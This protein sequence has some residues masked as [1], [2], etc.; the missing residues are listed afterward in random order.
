[1]AN[2][3]KYSLYSV[4]GDDE[5]IYFEGKP[6]KVAYVFNACKDDIPKFIFDVLF[7][8]III[9]LFFMLSADNFE[10]GAKAIIIVLWF[11]YLLPTLNMLKIPI[12]KMKE[13]KNTYYIITDK[14]IYIQFG[15]NQIYYRTYP[16]ERIG[17]KVFYRKNKADD[18]FGV[19]TLGFS[20][21]DY[22]EERIMS[23]KD[24]ESLYSVL[25]DITNSR[26]EEMIR[27]YEERQA[28]KRE[29]EEQA[30]LLAQE[31]LFLQQQ[32]EEEEKRR[33]E[34]YERE[35]QQHFEKE[36]ESHERYMKE[37]EERLRME[38]ELRNHYN[39][40]DDDDDDDEDE[41]SFDRFRRREQ[42]KKLRRQEEIDEENFET[43]DMYGFDAE[44]RPPSEK[45]IENYR[46][47]NTA[48]SAMHQR[49]SRRNERKS[50]KF[51]PDKPAE[52]KKSKF[53]MNRL[54]SGNND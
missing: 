16:K 26:K 2:K 17:T 5:N 38:R 39:D 46:R 44:E 41:E 27:E 50:I 25:K 1:M 33:H 42:I 4:L 37:R 52:V 31:E 35:M 28:K 7:K 45:T 20:V 30:R 34:K 48:S 3:R 49:T 15:V 6:N 12:L 19:G 13:Y 11:L 53:D 51:E 10:L 47:R 54:W 22:Y 43:Y 18:M 23:V 36:R 9:P 24:Y 32:E 8:M 40:D 21:D 14:S 29:F